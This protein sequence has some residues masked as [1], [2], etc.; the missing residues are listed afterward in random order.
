MQIINIFS[1]LTGTFWQF[2][3]APSLGGFQQLSPPLLNCFFQSH[4]FDSHLIFV[5]LIFLL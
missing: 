2:F 5:L 4:G 3:W 1:K